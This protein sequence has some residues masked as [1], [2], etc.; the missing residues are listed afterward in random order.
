[1]R[2]YLPVD[3][4]HNVVVD[5]VGVDALVG[6]FDGIGESTVLKPGVYIN[7]RSGLWQIQC[8]WNTA[9]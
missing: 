5:G 6:V 4:D 9:E 7:L 1:M 8:H 2:D 3:L